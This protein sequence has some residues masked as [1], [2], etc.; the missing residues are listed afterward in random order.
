LRE[1]CNVDTTQLTRRRQ[2]TTESNYTV[3]SEEFPPIEAEVAEDTS[4]DVSLHI[5]R[6][7]AENAVRA[8]SVVALDESKEWADKS[9]PTQGE[10]SRRWRRLILVFLC[11]ILLAVVAT[12]AA[13]VVMLTK[14]PPA[15]RR[16][17]IVIKSDDHPEETGWELHQGSE[18]VVTYPPGTYRGDNNKEIVTKTDVYAGEEYTFTLYDTGGNGS[19]GGYYKIYDAPDTS[20]PSTSSGR[21]IRQFH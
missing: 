13:V 11:L 19:D 17:T 20:D 21:R 1:R 8:S 9:A 10:S 15:T 5:R 3:V 16:I 2:N 12:V 4:T 18:E 6:I 14:D 7:L